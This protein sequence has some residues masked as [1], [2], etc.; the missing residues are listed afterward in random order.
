MAFALYEFEAVQADD[1]SLAKVNVT[2]VTVHILNY[3]ILIQ[4]NNLLPP[5]T[6][7][8][9][10]DREVTYAVIHSSYFFETFSS[11]IFQLD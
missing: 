5:L 7:P 2:C 9:I 11:F 8:T 10:P 6:I 4:I 3:E 1:I